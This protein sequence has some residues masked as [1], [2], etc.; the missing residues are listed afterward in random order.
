MFKTATTPFVDNFSMKF[1]NGLT[2]SLAI[3]PG[4]YSTGDAEN[5]FVTAEVGAWDANGDF[6]ELEPG[7][8]VIG[9]QTP[10]QVLA[11]MNKVAAM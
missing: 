1:A 2:V 5:G 7:S 11:I 9:W 10:E 8:D 6:I 3:G 4:V